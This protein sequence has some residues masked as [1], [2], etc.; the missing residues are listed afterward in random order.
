MPQ[1]DRRGEQTHGEQ[2]RAGAAVTSTSG[3]SRSTLD[4]TLGRV[5]EIEGVIAAAL[6]EAGSGMLL[7]GTQVGGVVDPEVIAAAAADI[8]FLLTELVARTGLEDELEGVVV[9]LS[10]RFHILRMLR[11]LTPEPV[12]LAV[13]L[14]RG[15]TNLAMAQREIRELGAR[16]GG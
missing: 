6:V 2:P 10:G 16:F 9:T 11:G 5:L 12:V 3:A 7:T 1:S 14:D 4:E 13:T 15:E 8:T